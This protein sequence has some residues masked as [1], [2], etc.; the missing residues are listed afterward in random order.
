MNKQKAAQFV[1]KL[2]NRTLAGE[3]PWEETETADVF[4]VSFADFSVRIVKE[5]GD[6]VIAIHNSQ[7]RLL[8]SVADP[9]LVDALPQQAYPFCEELYQSARGYAMGVEQA[10]DSLISQLSESDSDSISR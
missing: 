5:A 4:Q 9:D 7:G 8:D 3:L 10:L 2:H 1:T 6:I